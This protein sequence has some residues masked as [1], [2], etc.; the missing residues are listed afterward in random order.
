MDFETIILDLDGPVAR[1]T[2]NRPNKLNATNITMIEEFP[3][4]LAEVARKKSLR[5]LVL[6]GSGSAFC[7]GGDIEI[8]S[9]MTSMSIDER[10]SEI[11]GGQKMIRDLRALEIPTIAMVNGD[12]IG[13]GFDVTLACDIRIGSENA[14]FMIGFTGMGLTVGTGGTWMLPRLVGPDRAADILFTNRF[15]GAEEAERIGLISR[16]V[17][18]EELEMETMKLADRISNGPPIAI[19]L[20][21]S[22]IQ[23]GLQLDFDTALNMAMVCQ[24]TAMSS[25]DHREAVVAFKEKRK[26]VFKGD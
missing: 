6:T 14:R 25:Q 5:T 24:L 12:A 16:L 23:K 10:R 3:V 7:A 8:L 22:Q 1:I 18:Q 15:V 2:L 11:H 13:V 21:K 9:Q 19:K 26:P 17:P 20:S 4:A